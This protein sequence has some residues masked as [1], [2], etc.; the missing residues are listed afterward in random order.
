MKPLGSS[1]GASGDVLVAPVKSYDDREGILRFVTDSLDGDPETAA[2]LRTADPDRLVVVKPNWIQESHEYRPDV[3]E[4]VITHPRIL[5]PIVETLAAYMQGRGTICICDAP[6]TY[7]D[8]S[9]IVARGKLANGIEALL[10]RW[11]ALRI[12][13]LDLRRETWLRKEEVIVE[14]C[15]NPGDP[16][17]YVQLDLSRDSLFYGHRG[18]GSY[19]GADYDSTV[20]NSHHCGTVQEY[21][22]AGSPMACD[23]FINVP[24]L[25]THKKT[26]ITC[27]LKNL[28]GINGDKDW[29]P[30]HTEGAPS[31]DGDEFPAPSFSHFIE[32]CLKRAGR[33]SALAIPGLGTWAYR[34]A[35]NVGKMALGDSG[36]VVRNGNWSGNDTCWRMALDL[37]RCLLYGN[38]DGSWRE[39]GTGKRYLAIVDGILAGEGDGPLCPEPVRSGVLASGADP[40][41][42]DAVAA[43]LMG[44]PIE[45]LPMVT[46]AFDKHRWPI[47]DRQVDDVVVD[48]RRAGGILGLRD[49]APAVPGGFK[50]HFGWSVLR[51]S[52]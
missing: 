4:P 32:G 42:L 9:A 11:P 25:K 1:H 40:A 36:K 48:D 22:L 43:C 46:R 5:L 29:L 26:G 13:L 23:L 41:A 20:V 6:H 7:A 8:F 38:R 2:M 15:P 45:T 34:K 10:A 30:H 14:R 31:R 35:R 37:N 12:E 49:L 44:F 51:D 28:V 17:G 3:W 50:P 21:L 19:F 33:R 47:T 27:A 18:E 24:K 16:R 52:V 39:A